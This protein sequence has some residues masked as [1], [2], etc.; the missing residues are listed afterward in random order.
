MVEIGASIGED[1]FDHRDNNGLGMWVKTRVARGFT[2]QWEGTTVAVWLPWQWLED[3][4]KLQW[5]ASSQGPLSRRWSRQGMKSTAQ[6]GCSGESSPWLAD[7]EEWD[8]GVKRQFVEK[9]N[10][11]IKEPEVAEAAVVSIREVPQPIDAVDIVES[12]SNDGGKSQPD[13]SEMLVGGKT[14]AEG[15]II[16]TGPIPLLL[17][18][19]NTIPGEG[20]NCAKR[21]KLRLLLDMAIHLRFLE[22]LAMGRRCPLRGRVERHHDELSP[23][24]GGICRALD[25]QRS[26]LVDHVHF[27]SKRVDGGRSAAPCMGD[28]ELLG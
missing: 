15:S 11:M 17:D 4:G 18:A 24:N 12:D 8:E 20:Y 19:R 10:V 21:P 13:V 1:D 6:A 5:E 28:H 25:V 9:W 7:D 23:E 16:G 14:S 22:K 26:G 2:D 27:M 3:G